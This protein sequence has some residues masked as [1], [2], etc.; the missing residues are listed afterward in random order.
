MAEITT[1][2]TT[3]AARPPVRAALLAA[4][5]I[6]AVTLGIA[7]FELSMADWPSGFVL[8]VLVPLMALTFIG[9]GLWSMTLLR[10]IPR[11]GVRHGVKFAAPF[12][13]Y[14]L[15]LALLEYAP[16]QEIA[17]QR[18]FAWHRTS[19]ERVVARIEAGELKP[20]VEHN[21]NLIALGDGEANV[22]AGGN[23]IV[24]DRAEK[25]SY[26]LFLTSRGLKH[27]FSGFLHVPE[28]ADPNNFFEF[29]DKPPSRLVRYDKD[30]YFVAN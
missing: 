26:V 4:L 16:L 10:H 3:S 9:C 29:D 20:N 13:I 21:R 19:R 8:L 30:W 14:A 24:V 18:N 1:S 25:G 2:T 23:D 12:L 11:H 5:V 27:T 7:T 22:S 28:G 6:S 17:L 15:T